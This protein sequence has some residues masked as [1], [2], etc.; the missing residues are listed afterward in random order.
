MKLKINIPITQNLSLFKLIKTDI[1]KKINYLQKEQG[2][3]KTSQK[4]WFI[5]FKPGFFWFKLAF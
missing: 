3:Q 1:E 4:K 5:W 2:W